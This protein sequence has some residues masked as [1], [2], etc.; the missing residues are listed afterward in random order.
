MVENTH[1]S[2]IDKA[3]FEKVQKMNIAQKY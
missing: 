3:I 1:E 2:I